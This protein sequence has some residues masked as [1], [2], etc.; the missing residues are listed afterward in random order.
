MLFGVISF[1]GTNC[2]TESVR[3]LKKAGFDA[4]I[5]LWNEPKEHFDVCDGFLL[6]G[7]F[8]YEDRG[9][10]G[11]IA[12][13]DNVISYLREASKKGKSIIG[14]CNGAQILVESGLVTDSVG[15]KIALSI[16]K[17]VKEGHVQGIGFYHDWC[18]LKNI[19]EKGRSPFN[20]FSKLIKMPLAHGEGRFVIE[21]DTLKEM[22]KNDQIVFEYTDE[23]GKV[24]EH[25][26]IN[27]NGSIKNIAG[28]CNKAGNVLAMMP[29]PERGGEFSEDLFTGLKEWVNNNNGVEKSKGLSSFSSVIPAP[30]SVIPA[31]AGI[32]HG[33]GVNAIEFFIESI[34]TDNECETIR[35]VIEKSIGEEISLKRYRYF[36]VELVPSPQLLSQGERGNSSFP[37]SCLGT[38][39][40]QEAQASILEQALKI[41]KTDELANPN[42]ETIYVKIENTFYKFS[43]AKGIIPVI[44]APVKPAQ[45]PAGIHFSAESGVCC[46]LASE[47]EDILGKSKM[48][49]LQH[50]EVDLE[51][52]HSGTAWVFP[53]N[54]EDKVLEIGVLANPVSMEVGVLS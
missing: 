44:P 12:A 2:E 22:E 25:Y 13:N 3:A 17:R 42:K 40:S 33:N 31:E 52:I 4:K 27:P 19:A 29:H 8:S 49:K 30:S 47:K 5:I 7:G 15:P 48:E 26:P 43:K 46:L 35:S 24:D 38:Q 18:Y 39:L 1:P 14:I 23:N 37:N 36:S 51:A 53:K 28:V 54:L 6:A 11:V 20:N 34:I 21:A 50:E 10:S 16:N 41:I 32:H 45:A 9:R